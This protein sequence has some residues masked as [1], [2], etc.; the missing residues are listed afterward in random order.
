MYALFATI[1]N[2]FISYHN[3]NIK[4]RYITKQYITFKVKKLK[5]KHPQLQ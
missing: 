2:I 1:K 3:K 4:D 5:A